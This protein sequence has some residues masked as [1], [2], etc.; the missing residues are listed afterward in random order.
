M[1]FPV[2]ELLSK[3]CVGKESVGAERWSSVKGHGKTVVISAHY[4][5]SQQRLDQNSYPGGRQRK[6]HTHTLLYSSKTA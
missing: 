4:L 5:I 3:L 1:L 6:K 2:L